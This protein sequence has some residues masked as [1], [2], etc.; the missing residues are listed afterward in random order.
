MSGVILKA[1]G[2]RVARGPRTVLEVADLT[3][4][5]GEVIAV[6]GPNGA[7][8]STLLQ[9]VAGLLP[10]ACGHLSF[11]G[12]HVGVELSLL[13]YHRRTAAVFQEPLLLQGS[14]RHNVSLGLRLRGVPKLEQ[15]GRIQVWLD[16]L[17]IAHL[18]DRSVRTLSAG[19]AQ[20]TS[21]AR[22]LV[23][24]P[25]VLFLDEPFAALDAPTHSRLVE[26]LT[27]I[28]AERQIATLLVT[29]DLAEAFT[30]S[31]RCLILDQGR[32]LQ[33]GD[34]AALFRCPRS[35]RVAEIT[36]A[37][38]LFEATVTSSDAQG[39]LLNWGGVSLRSACTVTTPAGSLVDF[40]I[41]SEEISFDSRREEGRSPNGL[42]GRL[43]NVRKR[44]L[45]CTIAVAAENQ[46]V[47]RLSLAE[48]QQLA[49]GHNVS[50]TFPPE[51]IWIFPEGTG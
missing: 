47:L 20:R 42:L 34:L 36:G 31:H 4:H 50:L 49:P 39:T 12:R 16:R 32:V 14:V 13:T 5:A 51:A 7:G 30:L 37:D 23:L 26:E 24:E 29:H 44:G 22:A 45:G 33:D 27:A 28:L 19:E 11:K 35:R 43:M 41:R 10:L 6:Y 25:E 15:E 8:K 21:L 17:R 18:A 38:N 40:L 2:L 48:A 1:E 9:A 3:L 46:A